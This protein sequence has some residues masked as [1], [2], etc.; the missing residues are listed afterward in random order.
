ML[1]NLRVENDA[2]SLSQEK[3]SLISCDLVPHNKGMQTRW[4]MILPIIGLM[5]F[6]VVSYRSMP[7]NEHEEEEPRKYYW[8]SSLRLD[9]DPLNENPKL[10]S[11]CGDGKQNCGRGEIPGRKITPSWADRVLIISALPAFLAGAAMVVLLSKAGV[12]EV[13]SFMVSMPVLLF[14]WYYFV[15]WLIERWGIHR[16]QAKEVPVK[17]T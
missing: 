2:S 17:M 15:G 10:T 8:W 7:V 14:V 12:D 6:A 4:S 3:K 11:A 9:S 13:L 1:L 5:L 16:A